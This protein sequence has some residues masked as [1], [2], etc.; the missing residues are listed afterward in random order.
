MI[1]FELK[2][3]P[4]LESPDDELWILFEQGKHRGGELDGKWEMVFEDKDM[5]FSG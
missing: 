4:T 1:L 3:S 5:P 2:I